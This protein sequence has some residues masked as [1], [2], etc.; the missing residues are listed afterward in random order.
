MRGPRT[1]RPRWTGRSAA[2]CLRLPPPRWRPIRSRVSFLIF[3]AAVLVGRW[4]HLRDLPIE[5]APMPQPLGDFTLKPPVGGKVITASPEPVG[6]I[7]RAGGVA[8]GLVVGVTVLLAVAK[9]LHES[10]RGIAQMQRH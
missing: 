4:R 10:G 2:C 9:L 3:F 7:V 6:K 1:R 5:F 8:F